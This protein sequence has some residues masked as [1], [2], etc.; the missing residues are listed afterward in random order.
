[1]SVLDALW[2]DRDVRFDVSSQQMKTRPGEALIDCLDSIEDTKGNNGDRAIGYNCILNITTRTANSKLRG[3][4]EAL[5]ILTKCNSTRFEFIFTNLVPGSPRLFTSVIA[6][7]RAY[8]TSKMYRDFKLRSALI[9]NKQLRLLPQ[10][11]V[12]DKINGVWNLSSDQ[13][14]LGTFFITNVRIVWHANM[15]DSFNVSIPYLQI[16]S[17]KIRDSKFGLAL[18]IES[19]QQSGGYVL[20]FKID[21]VEKLQESVKEINSLHKVYSASPIFGVDYEME[22]KPQPLEALTVEQIQD[23]VEIDSD[24]HTDA[25]VA[26]FADGNKVTHKMDSQRELTEELR[27]YQ[28]TLLQDGLKDLLDEKKFIDCTLKAG[29]KSLPCH[30]L[31]LS[32]C[33]PYF[34]EYFLS[35][36][37]EGK[38][39]EV[40]LDNVDPAVLDLIIKYL[41]SASI[42]LNDGNVQDIFALASRFQI[43]SVFTVC[44]SYLQKRLAPGNCL[45]ILRLGLLLDCPRLAISAREFVS[46]RFVQIC[47][48]EDF[49]QLSPQE[50]I[51]VI[52]NDSL[53]VEKEEAVFEA[54]MKWVRTDKENRVK[55]LSEVF[56]CIRFRLM[57]EKYFKD[58]VEKDDIIKSNPE[59]QKKIKV[60]K[61]AFAGKL[62]EPSKNAEKSGAGEVNGDVGDEDLLPGYLNDIPRHGMFVKDLI[63]LVND[64]AAVAYD[65]TENEC[66]LTALAE[67]IPRNH[68]SIVT[69]QNQVYVVGGLYV[70]EENKD[71]PLQSY[72][73]QLDNIASEWV[74]LPPLPSARCLFGLG[75][76]DDKIYVVAGKDLQTEASLDSVLCYDPVT[77]KWNE[78]KKLPIKVYGHSVISHKGMIYC[79]GGKT[80]DK[81]CTNRVFIYNPKKGDWKDVAPMK[82]PRSMFGVAIHKG[83]IVIA[84][85]VTEDGLSA[86]VEAFDLI[87]NKW[88]VMTEFPQERSS[89]SLVSLA[90]SL[91]AI[92][93]FA[94]IQLE[95]KE[96]APTEVNDIW[97]YEDDKKE[98]AGML[99]EIRYA[100]GASCLATRLNLFKLSKL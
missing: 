34:R 100:S 79:L 83:K 75:E 19:S 10:E 87:T 92:G 63:L 50:L 18:V 98:W 6:V 4:S 61:D 21:P 31:I 69:Q 39:K 60:L 55:N 35:E 52:S 84:G 71:Q 3:Q 70:D 64:T 59:L 1:M 43:P 33:S 48:E 12:Y 47:K 14:N 58:H 2:E 45:A 9:Q 17:I 96:F 29:D 67:Q 15:N 54:V 8:E 76:V 62:P 94:M 7:H 56:D 37:D 74:G 40:V 88:E 44:V 90:G 28:S 91:Y 97:K 32:A 68:S 93:G 25:F 77:A 78:V 20:G 23:D 36:I 53:N 49:M 16:R 89:I 41:Y 86:S 82:T 85:G 26:Y 57:T 81:K 80:D 51:S 22:E 5:Y 30:R 46:D 99:K 24:D 27:L 66:Y 72:F 95:S 38:K 65:P 13:G 11:H 42:D 73:F